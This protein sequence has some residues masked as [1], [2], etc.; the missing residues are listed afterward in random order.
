MVAAALIDQH[1]AADAPTQQAV[2]TEQQA[3]AVAADEKIEIA[4]KEDK[5]KDGRDN[6]NAETI[7]IVSETVP[8]QT[9]QAVAQGEGAFAQDAEGYSFLEGSSELPAPLM[10]WALPVSCW[11]RGSR[12]WCNGG[13]FQQSAQRLPD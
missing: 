4:K 8:T 6:Q 11:G 7:Q 9:A 12:R 3:Q 13:G 2:E 10:H 1:P 5:D